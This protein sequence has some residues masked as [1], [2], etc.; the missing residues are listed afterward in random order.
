MVVDLDKDTDVL[1]ANE[2]QDADEDQDVDESWDTDEDQY[3]HRF[4]TR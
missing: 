4:G 1:D 2:V 3:V